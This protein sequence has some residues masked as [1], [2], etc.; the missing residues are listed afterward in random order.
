MTCL[1]E[2]ILNELYRKYAGEL[3][4]Y[5]FALCRDR[6]LAED[7]MQEAFLKALIS[8]PEGHANARSWIYIVAR[9]LLFN[10]WKKRKREIPSEDFPME[11]S[12][13]DPKEE[14]IKRD[15]ASALRRAMLKLDIRKR[16]V[17]ELTYFEHFTLRE[18]AKIMGLT[19]ENAR[20]LSSRARRE[21]RRIMEVEK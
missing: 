11:Q 2:K 4:A 3:L 20:V 16:E 12:G 17:L 13:G 9:N 6:M 15:E 21:M 1:D 8:L 18:A 5:L 10:E 19:H 7:V 14:M